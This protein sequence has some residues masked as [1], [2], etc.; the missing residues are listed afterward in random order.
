MSDA[1]ASAGHPRP[2]LAARHYVMLRD[3]A[4]T[5]G[6]LGDPSKARKTFER[7]LTGLLRFTND[8]PTADDAPP[9]RTSRES[10]T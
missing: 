3:G 8:P 7:A 6:H 4:T 9:A 1:F 2:D 5:A 10:K